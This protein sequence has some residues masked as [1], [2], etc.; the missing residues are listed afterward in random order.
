MP[1]GLAD[2][3]VRRLMARNKSHR[4]SSAAEAA[5]DLGRFAAPITVPVWEATASVVGVPT[6][7]D[8][9]TTSDSE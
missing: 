1:T 2:L 3:V 6:T 7:M 8:I 5:A 9:S 4:I